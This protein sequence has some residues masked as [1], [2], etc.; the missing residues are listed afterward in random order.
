MKRYVALLGRE[1]GD[2]L[3]QGDYLL[4]VERPG[5]DQGQVERPHRHQHHL[6]LVLLR[7]AVILIAIVVA[8]C[9]VRCVASVIV[10]DGGLS[11]YYCLPLA[12]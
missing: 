1:V 6:V 2:L 12:H 8:R 4:L 3:L 11:L 9:I 7:L 10:A 5:V